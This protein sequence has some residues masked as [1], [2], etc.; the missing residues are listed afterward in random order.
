[1]NK[2]VGW[3]KVSYNPETGNEFQGR[4][5]TIVSLM[6]EIYR[7]ARSD[8][9]VLILGEPGTGKELIARIIHN[10]SYRKDCHFIIIDCFGFASYELV[11]SELWGHEKGVLA[12][13]KRLGG[14][15]QA[16][17][18]TIFLNEL[19]R[20]EDR[21]QSQLLRFYE[22]GQFYPLG[23]DR[24]HEANVRIIAST[25]LDIGKA[26][27][28]GIILRDLYMRLGKEIIK[29]PSLRERQATEAPELLL[30]SDP[31][32]IHDDIEILVDYAMDR[33][34]K[35]EGI[36]RKIL[37]IEETALEVLKNFTWPGNVRQLNHVIN[38]VAL[39]AS[40]RSDNPV[41]T[42]KDVEGD[43]LQKNYPDFGPPSGSNFADLRKRMLF[44]DNTDKKQFSDMVRKIFDISGNDI[45]K[46]AELAGISEI[47]MRQYIDDLK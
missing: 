1:M 7:I 22:T 30:G 16:D 13:N 31:L 5:N 34:N 39:K 4:S 25:S 41:I 20:F 10:Y 43:V 27:R 14:V 45:S 17:G 19:G 38:E 47:G 24:I 32:P 37:A 46:A 12:V 35:T 42:R 18:G 6:K 2:A 15:I 29:I 8:S 9:N 26:I 21:I 40:S 33:Y 28:D 36:K 23:S 11:Y 44:G 3:T